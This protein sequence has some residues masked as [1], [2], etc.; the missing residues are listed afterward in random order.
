MK[1]KGVL[2]AQRTPFSLIHGQTP[3]EASIPKKAGE[4]LKEKSNQKEKQ[5][6]KPGSIQIQLISKFSLNFISSKK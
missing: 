3:K 5:L 4:R 2:K 1:E 6:S